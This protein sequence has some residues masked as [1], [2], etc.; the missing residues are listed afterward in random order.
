MS[1]H[2][3]AYGNFDADMPDTMFNAA[4][5]AVPPNFFDATQGM[6]TVQVETYVENN[7]DTVPAPS[8]YS[9]GHPLPDPST[10]DEYSGNQR[11]NTNIAGS[12]DNTTALTAAEIAT[13]TAQGYMPY[14]YWRFGR[15]ALA[16]MLLKKPALAVPR[17]YIVEEYRVANFM[18]DYGAGRAISNISLLPGEKTTL[19][20]RTYKNSTFT[21]AYSENVLDSFGTNSAAEME[22]LVE[23]E[24]STAVVKASTV[25]KT[26]GLS[27]ST[28]SAI[29]KLCGSFN[30]SKTTNKTSSRSAN[31]RQLNKALAKHVETSNSN[32]QINVN[33]TTTE[34]VTEGSESTT[35][36]ILENPNKSRVLNFVTRQLQQEYI[37]LTYLAN[38]RIAFCNGYSE[39]IKVV[40]VEEL[41][42]LLDAIINPANI[43]EARANILK[44]Y[45]TIQNWRNDEI[46]FI[47]HV[48][49]DIGGC[50]LPAIEVEQYYR[51]RRDCKDTYV[52]GGR[53]FTV[54]GPI[55]AAERHVLHTDAYITDAILGTGEALDCFNQKVEDA[56]IIGESLK[57]IAALQKLLAIESLP[58]QEDKIK[59]LS[60][61]GGDCCGN[62]SATI[63]E[64]ATQALQLIA[65]SNNNTGSGGTT[66]PIDPNP[67]P[68][69]PTS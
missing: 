66:P 55:L 34:M 25:G 18:G 57:N 4:A 17:I 49:R 69:N 27:L 67:N 30:F 52:Y 23:E 53:N 6:T 22:N 44:H 60:L 5:S 36:R 2:F 33:T 62:I 24:N 39:S 40:E 59:A 9:Q 26:T 35:I 45:C 46:P 13:F 1:S 28:G 41:D 16:T 37:S 3:S 11:I 10:P 8:H 54:D 38:I 7:P 68:E 42:S 63:R 48:N 29:T 58:T 50:I 64:V 19:S 21:R 31:S 56:A 43:T 15:Y 47:E 12:S 61:L 32:R 51:K 65:A 14:Q 20:I